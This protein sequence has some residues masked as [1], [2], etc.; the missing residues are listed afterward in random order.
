MPTVRKGG[1]QLIKMIDKYDMKQLNKEEEICKGLQTRE[2]GKEKRKDVKEL[3]RMRKKPKERISSR[4]KLLQQ[5]T[6]NRK[7]K[8]D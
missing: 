6:N 8:N 2:Q 5:K 7:N 1:R 4:N 3:I